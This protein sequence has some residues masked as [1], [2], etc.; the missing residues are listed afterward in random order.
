MAFTDSTYYINDINI[1]SGALSDLS[2]YIDKFEREMLL[3]VFTYT[4]YAEL[5][6]AYAAS[7]ATVPT[8]LPDKWDRLVNG[9]TYT[10]SGI[11]YRWNGL[12]NT[13]KESTL[14]YYVYCQYLKTHQSYLLQTGTVQPKNENSSPADPNPSFVSAWN[15]FAFSYNDMLSFLYQHDTDYSIQWQ[16]VKQYELTNQFGI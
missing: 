10:V 16:T 15:K 1:P 7:I 2:Q 13:A 4:Q 14:A 11:E 8:P 12:L 3:G 6:A 9:Y 5:I